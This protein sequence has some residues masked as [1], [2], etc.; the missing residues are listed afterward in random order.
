[1]KVRSCHQEP[2]FARIWCEFSRTKHKQEKLCLYQQG[3]ASIEEQ[4]GAVS[5]K[6][7]KVLFLLPSEKKKK[8]QTIKTNWFHVFVFLSY[9]HSSSK[10]TSMAH[11]S[12]GLQRS[13]KALNKFWILNSEYVSLALLLNG[14]LTTLQQNNFEKWVW[15]GLFPINDWM[16]TFGWWK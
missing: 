7:V 3:F 15:E 14:F 6:E 11:H 16:L 2:S 13:R 8:K 12:W 4:P 5:L 10:L 1:M 9:S